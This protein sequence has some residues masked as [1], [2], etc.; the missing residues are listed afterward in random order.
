ME[1]NEDLIV[2]EQ[3]EA[4]EKLNQLIDQIR[5]EKD[6]AVK[7]SLLTLLSVY[8]FQTSKPSDR[9][10]STLT[11]DEWEEMSDFCKF[12]QSKFEDE[13]TLEEA[14]EIHTELNPKI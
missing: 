5:Q 8:L 1:L 10:D 7:R 6:E 12:E 11:D 14:V 2:I 13:N 4:K 3:Q 9:E